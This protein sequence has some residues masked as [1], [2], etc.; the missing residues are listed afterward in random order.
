MIQ[1]YDAGNTNFNING[2]MA[3]QPISAVLSNAINTIPSIEL[4]LNY[5]EYKT[6]DYIT[7]QSVI[8]CA[9]PWGLDLFRVY[10]I[11]KDND[12]IK[13]YGRHVFADLMNT[14]A[15]DFSNTDIG[16]VAT[17]S[18]I[19]QSALDKLL[20]NTKF[21][22][23]SNISKLDSVRWERKTITQALLSDDDNSFVKRWGGELFVNNFDIYMNDRIGEDNG[24]RI[25]YGKN[26]D[27]IEQT[28]KTDELATRIIPVG[29][30]GL[31]LVGK[32]PWVDSPNVN[33][34]PQIYEKVVEFS[35]V[36][37]KE[38]SDD[39][40]GFATEDLARQELIRLSNLMFSEQHV[41]TPS[42]NIK[43]NMLD[44]RDSIEYKQLGYSGLEVIN[45]GD[46]VICTHS[47]LGIETKA[48]CISYKWDVLTEKMQEIEIGD[49]Q[50]NYFDKQ[51]DSVSKLNNDVK[52]QKND[53]LKAIDNATALI[54][55]SKG[56]NVI[57]RKNDNGQPS[58]I[59]I[60]DTT[61]ITTAKKVWRW[62]LN[63]FGYS[64]TGVD[65]TYSTAI[66]MDGS[67]VGSFIT[68]L[69]IKGEQIT[70]GVISGASL[71]T[72]N[73][74]NYMEVHD[75]VVDLYING[76]IQMRMGI[77]PWSGGSNPYIA[78]GKYCNDLMKCKN[79][80][81]FAEDEDGTGGHI[82]ITTDDELSLFSNK[83]V[84]INAPEIHLVGQVYKN[85]T[86]I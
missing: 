7:E 28:I 6:Y 3:I 72:S 37:V 11:E 76:A 52:E 73:S 84:T 2:D 17:G 59:L 5:D 77:D 58:E 12:Y 64:S 49:V 22:G 24:V 40:E 86:A 71:K 1:I 68:A 15:K 35:N 62:N 44:I 81:W 47:K 45:L 67:I 54:T 63:G 41:D 20:L 78:F 21:I 38:S 53:L 55:G 60:M 18:C 50:L 79:Y 74:N 4:E 61:D 19:G 43:T 83:M 29:A 9:T 36:K 33:K 13:A 80:I 14:L 42:I 31:H 65:G 30:N 82:T 56:G 25:S 34:Y 26:L 46:T 75:Q 32:T 23:H 27:S 39:S 16:I 8:K 48:R 69:S 66:T 57:I 10:E 51:N 70:G 85:G